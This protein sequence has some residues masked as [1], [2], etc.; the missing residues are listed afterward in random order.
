[1]DKQMSA[2]CVKSYLNAFVFL[3]FCYC[4]VKIFSLYFF[5]IFTV[6]ICHYYRLCQQRDL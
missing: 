6:I 4:E 3:S 1:M 2:K 5:L